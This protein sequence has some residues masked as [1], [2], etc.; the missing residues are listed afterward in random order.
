MEF[1][2]WCPTD[3]TVTV[4]LDDIDSIVVRSGS[5]VEVMFVCPLCGSRIALAARVPQEMLAMLDDAWVRVDD[6]EPTLI[7]LRRE[8]SR[9]HAVP[10][11]EPDGRVEA[12]CEYFRRELDD[13]ETVEDILAEIDQRERS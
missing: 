9:A 11:P 7:T 1:S 2:I 10:E 12:Y 6:G 8:G 5:D 3:G 4:G 13:V